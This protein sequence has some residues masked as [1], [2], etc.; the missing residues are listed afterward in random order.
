MG[1]V[2]VGKQALHILHGRVANEKGAM[3]KHLLLPSRYFLRQETTLVEGCGQILQG[4]HDL[5]PQPLEPGC[6]LLVYGI[7]DSLF[8]KVAFAGRW[9]PSSRGW[10]TRS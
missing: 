8:Q 7:L 1:G 9:H 10:G 3:K 2:P 4:R 6:H 5:V